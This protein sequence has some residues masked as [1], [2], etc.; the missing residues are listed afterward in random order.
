MANVLMNRGWL[1][2]FAAAILCLAAFVTASTASAAAGTVTN[3]TIGSATVAPNG[4]VTVNLTFSGT[5]IGA[6]GVNVKYDSTKVTATACTATKGSC[7][8]AFAA[9]TVRINGAD[10]NGISGTNVIIGTITF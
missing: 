7:N 4:D 8:E 2:A 1:A 6:V 5:N 10:N 9:E 3:V